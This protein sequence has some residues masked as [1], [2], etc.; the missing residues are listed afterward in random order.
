M[1]SLVVLILFARVSVVGVSAAPGFA[2]RVAAPVCAP[3]FAKRFSAA[4]LDGR[5][6]AMPPVAP[7]STRAVVRVFALPVASGSVVLL[8]AV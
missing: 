1:A 6:S 3:R 2:A 4:H 5:F 8:V 7:H